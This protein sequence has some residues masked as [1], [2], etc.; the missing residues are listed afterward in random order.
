VERSPAVLK[1][2]PKRP[3]LPK[4]SLNLEINPPVKIESLV[5]VHASLEET[6]FSESEQEMDL[7]VASLGLELEADKKKKEPFSSIYSITP[8]P[9]PERSTPPECHSSRISLDPSFFDCSRISDNDSPIKE[10]RP[11]DTPLPRWTKAWAE[12]HQLNY[13]EKNRFREINYFFA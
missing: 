10:C 9:F 12:Q 1:K 7:L 13:L 8:P 11:L 2:K 5:T 3:C 4:Q 6:N